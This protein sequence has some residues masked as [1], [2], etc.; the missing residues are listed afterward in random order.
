V[1]REI[2]R[3]NRLWQDIICG[4]VH[5]L[6]A[7]FQGVGNGSGDW[8]IKLWDARTGELEQ[9]SFESLGGVDSVTFSAMGR[10]SAGRDE[11]IRLWTLRQGGFKRFNTEKG[12]VRC[13][14]LFS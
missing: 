3:S 10:F 2:R 5:C 6:F 1:G 14:Y 7:R 4:L 12:T 9:N 8:T 13:V 11:A